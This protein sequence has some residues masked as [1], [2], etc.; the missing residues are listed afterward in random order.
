MRPSANLSQFYVISIEYKSLMYNCSDKPFNQTVTV[1]SRQF[2][3]SNDM[4]NTY[5][6]LFK[7]YQ[8]W[9]SL[10]NGYNNMFFVTS[11]CEMCF[12]SIATFSICVASRLQKYFYL[13]NVL[14]NLL[15]RSFHKA[16]DN[17][18]KFKCCPFVKRIQFC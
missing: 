12:S 10:R 13:K 15:K 7:K 2:A 1:T 8:T 3:L 6:S 9:F 17:P 14:V 18:S 16:I 11:L 4:A 5:S